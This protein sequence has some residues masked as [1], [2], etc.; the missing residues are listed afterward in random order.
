MH[1]RKNSNIL[2]NAIQISLCCLDVFLLHPI[3][4]KLVLYREAGEVSLQSLPYP[5]VN[6]KDDNFFVLI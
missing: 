6:I 2:N 3:S 4:L 5:H 1:I